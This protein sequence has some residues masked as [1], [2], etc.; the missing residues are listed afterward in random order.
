MKNFFR[1]LACF[2]CIVIGFISTVH[3]QD[4]VLTLTHGKLD[5]IHSA[6]LNQERQVQVFVP[7]DYKPGSGQK[8]DV[9]YV[10]DGGNWNTGLVSRVQA[11]LG[12]EGFIPSTIIVSVMGI[13][14]NVE[15]TPT[16]V[17]DFKVSGGGPAFLGYIKNEL[18]PYINKNY[19]SNGDNTLWGHSLSAMFAI[20][21]MLNEPNL[22]KSY[23]AVDPSIWWDHE[24]VARIAA[25]K[26]PGITQNISLFIAGREG[27]LHGMKTDTMETVLKSYAPKNL[28]WKLQV[29]IGETHSSVRFKSTYDGLRFT[30][31]GMVSHIEF[32]PMNGIVLKDKP[33]PIWLF[34]DTTNLHYTLDG[35]IPT[36]ASPNVR[37]ILMVTGPST[38]TYKSIGNRSRYDQTVTGVFTTEKV[39]HPVDQP[40][41]FQPG[42]FNY[43]YYVLKGDSSNDLKNRKP[44]KT[45]ITGKDFDLDKLATSDNYA[46]VDDG[47]L[48]VKEDGYY[49]FG[50]SAGKGSKLYIAG[51]LMINRTGSPAQQNY[52][53]IIPLSKGFYPLRLEYYHRSQDF[54]LDWG[55]VTPGNIAKRN[56]TPIPL[57]LQY[58]RK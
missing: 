43:A 51:K 12:N 41:N 16:H 1:C 48:E 58:S 9:L 49:I 28:N 52:S 13:D 47:Y 54:K 33:Y 57:E 42:G 8:Y 5:S 10:L 14:R 35:T 38:V 24:Y 21:V 6:I 27:A 7:K 39:P 19:P 53:C 15:L 55:Y 4:T 29:Y 23:I 36:G 26:L 3:A 17:A 11:F 34:D 45:G 37:Q 31:Q 2:F 22:F 40:K 44:L 20:Y 50:L 30:Y 32:H 56:F 18:I 46:L 25:D